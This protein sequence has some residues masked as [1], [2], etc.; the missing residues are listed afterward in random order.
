MDERKTHWLVPLPYW[1]AFFLII[2]FSIWSH[3]L[4]IWLVGVALFAVAAATIYLLKRLAKRS[5]GP[6]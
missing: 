4:R 2:G 6:S 5:D 1:I 3:G